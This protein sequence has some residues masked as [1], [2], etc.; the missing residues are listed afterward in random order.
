MYTVVLF[1]T[2]TKEFHEFPTVYCHYFE[3]KSG[4]GMEL[5]L[6]QKYLF[7]PLDIFR[8]NQQNKG[9]TGKLDAWLTFL[10]MDD[11][12]V[13]LRLIQQWP[14]F[15][16]MYEEAYD[17]CRNIEG[18]MEMFSKELQELDRNTVQYMIDEMQETIDKQKE[19]LKEQKRLE[20]QKEK[21]W[22]ERLEEQL[23]ELR[24]QKEQELE[25]QQR[26]AAQR[27]AELEKQLRK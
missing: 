25:E 20:K 5:D 8:K 6:L 22:E 17:I 3:Q 1:D 21:Q 9:I 18:V 19:Q 12:E 16:P 7:V 15:K 26:K 13:I 2:S 10:S 27:I 11:P 24:K 14:E 4:T 23:E